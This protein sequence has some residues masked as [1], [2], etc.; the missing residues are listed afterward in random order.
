M[1]KSKTHIRSVGNSLLH[2]LKRR[3]ATTPTGLEDELW[4]RIEQEIKQNKRRRMIYYLKWSF[5]TAAVILIFVGLGY[6]YFNEEPDIKTQ[7]ALLPTVISEENEVILARGDNERLTI[8]NGATVSYSS[9]GVI[10]VNKTIVQQKEETGKDTENVYNQIIV[11]KGKHSSLLLADGTKLDI[12]AGSRVVYPS[13]FKKDKREIYIEGE[14]FLDVKHDESAPFIVKTTHFD[15]EVLGTAFNVNAYKDDI[16][17][18]VALLRGIVKIKGEHGG[19]LSLVP[20]ELASI[21]NGVIQG[22]ERVNAEEYISWTKGVFILK[23]ESL[24]DV[25]RK[26]ERYFDQKI[27]LTGKMPVEPLCG[28]ID[29]NEGIQEVIRFISVTAPITVE[30]QDGI[31]YISPK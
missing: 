7:I 12:N 11:P 10:S 14:V 21:R 4:Q 3:E 20:N 5:S 29:L 18:S 28:K 6:Y 26:L 27:V 9:R 13:R 8:E 25:F 23:N 24:D 22:K 17:S 31:I 15:I 30:E 16:K 1:D 19:D 2:Y